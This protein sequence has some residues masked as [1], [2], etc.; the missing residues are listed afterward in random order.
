MKPASRREKIVDRVRELGKISVDDLADNLQASRE[1]IRRDLTLLAE[2]GRIRKVHGA[3]VLS[4]S[5]AESAFHV[6][7]KEAAAEKRVVGERAADLFDS[8]DAMFVDTGTTTLFFAEALARKSGMTIITNS[9][10]VA[11]ALARGKGSNTIFMLGGEYKDDAA[12]NV[13][14]LAIEQISRFNAHHAV[15]TVGAITASGIMDFSLDEVGVARAMVERARTVTVIADGSKL[16]KEAL[17]EVCPLSAVSRLVINRRPE[18]A[19][20]KALARARVE[21]ILAEAP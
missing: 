9:I 17:F 6:R 4:E 14:P 1:T 20:A 11:Q 19:L 15:L 8:G 13:G 7:M 18:G 5:N 12:E 10:L 21:V 2:E 16:D 3:A